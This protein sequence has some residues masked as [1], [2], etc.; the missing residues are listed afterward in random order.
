MLFGHIGIGLAAK[1]AAPKVSL[2][3]LL[4]AATAL[5]TLFGV[6]FSLGIERVNGSIGWSHGLLMS[7]VWSIAA[8]AIVFLASRDFRAGIV[9]GLLVFS[10]WVLDFISHPM[11]MGRI[12]PPDLPL[13]FDGSPKVG[14]GLYTSV[15]AA[16]V[17]DLGLLAGGIVLYMTGTKAKDRVGVWAFWLMIAF[18]AA[19]PALVFLP[20]GLEG[21]PCLAQLLLLPFGLWVDRHRSVRAV[22]PR[23]AVSV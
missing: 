13:L 21:L 16:L 8:F 7:A 20:S 12:L 9:I 6:F 17:T 5:D 22:E 23:H 11:G 15:A 19:F 18:I 14:L 2:G 10:H 3:F 4:A 1:R